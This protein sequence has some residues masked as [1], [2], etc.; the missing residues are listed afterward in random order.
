[1]STD[2]ADTARTGTTWT[3]L[4]VAA[5]TLAVMGYAF[6]QARTFAD[7][8]MWFPSFVSLVGMVCS[9]AIIVKDVVTLVRRRPAKAPGTAPGETPGET[10]GEEVDAAVLRSVVYWL[11]WMVAL[12]LIIVFIGA[13]LGVPVWLFCFL[14]FAA[15]QTIRYS[16]I[17]ALA[18]TALL[19]LV[20]NM[21]DFY[22]PQGFFE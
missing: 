2:T 19:F 1:M 13:F 14:R 20:T 12:A 9:L 15:R 8:S 18:T 6:L 21:L 22:V 3:S 4:A 7:A 16:V 11:G 17:G 10:S 5:L